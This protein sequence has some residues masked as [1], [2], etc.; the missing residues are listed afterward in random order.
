MGERMAEEL[1]RTS[2]YLPGSVRT[3]ASCPDVTGGMCDEHKERLCR[4]V[5]EL[6]FLWV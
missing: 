1:L 6:N 2:A 3:L 4:R 5:I